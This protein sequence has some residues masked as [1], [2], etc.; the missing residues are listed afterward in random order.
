MLS[1]FAR[2]ATELERDAAT[3]LDVRSCQTVSSGDIGLIVVLAALDL[4]SGS[5]CFVSDFTFNSTGNASIWAG[6]R[7]ILVDIDDATFNMSPESL[8]AA[9]RRHP[10]PGVVLPTHVFGNPCAT[11]DIEALARSHQSFVVYD[12]AHAYGSQIGGESVGL[13]GDASVFSLS[14]TKLV[15]SGE[16]GLIATK[17]DWLS[18]N[19][20]YR[21]AYGFQND[22]R[23]EC[24]GVNGKMSELH[25]ALGLLSVR[26]VEQQVERRHEIVARYQERL[27]ARVGWQQLTTNSRSTFKDIAVLL[28]ESRNS[29][30]QALAQSGVQT[31]RYFMPLHDMPAFSHF[32]DGPLDTSAKIANEVL[33]LPCFSD[34]TDEQIDFVCAGILAARN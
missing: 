27:G 32:A 6:L 18:R 9:M 28:G 2:F 30:E 19:V 31:K 20:L 5:P 11:R 3:Y 1:N 22:Y 10:S 14:G 26:S 24:V 4:P 12:A 8:E 25:A 15:T 21:R 7:P 16:G 29:V 13:A 33:C 17:H 34:L 23:S